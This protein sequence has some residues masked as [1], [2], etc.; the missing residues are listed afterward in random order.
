MPVT[1]RRKRA[2]ALKLAHRLLDLPAA[3]AFYHGSTLIATICVAT[4][5]V[6]ND[7][8]SPNAVARK[9]I[10][11]FGCYGEALGAVPSRGRA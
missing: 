10:G 7:S 6:D 1:L 2:Q 8:Y 5:C 9:L 11:K 3:S 4:I